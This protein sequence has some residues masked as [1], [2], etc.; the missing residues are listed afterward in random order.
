MEWKPVRFPLTFRFGFIT[1]GTLRFSGLT[2]SAYFSQLPSHP[3]L[4]PLPRHGPHDVFVLKSHPVDAPLPRLQLRGGRLWYTAQ[5]Y[6]HQYTVLTGCFEDYLKGIPSK[7][8][9]TLQRKV[10]KLFAE[11]PDQVTVRCYRSPEELLEFHPLARTVSAH[12]YQE[13]ML[14]AGLPDTPEF[15]A[16]MCDLAARDSVR[17]FLLFVDRKPIAYLYSPAQDS[18]LLYD[19]LGYDTD[20]SKSS[21]GTVLQ[22]LAFEEL[23]REKRFAIFDFEEG[24]GQ[25]KRLF[26]T[27]QAECADV[28]VFPV[29]TRSV[30][31]VLLHAALGSITRTALTLAERTGIKP[32][33]KAELKK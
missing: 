25:H 8:R 11:W 14:K 5:N 9:S 17:A 31:L 20:Y 10:R 33:I 19:Y 22:Y 15:K 4:T 30:A 21:P 23:F 16:E 7:E 3:Y 28:Y 27:H 2:P 32:Q 1:L 29:R 13:R 6:K 26:S 18:V 12:T 24:E